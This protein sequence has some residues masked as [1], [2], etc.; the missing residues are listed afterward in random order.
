[1]ET[2]RLSTIRHHRRKKL[3]EMVDNEKIELKN[4]NYD[5]KNENDKPIVKVTKPRKYKDTTYN[6]I[7]IE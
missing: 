4:I 2:K 3:N 1:M 5:N 6:I 7:S